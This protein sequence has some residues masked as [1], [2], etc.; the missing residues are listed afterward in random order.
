MPH[1]RAC[2]VLVFSVVIARAV[3]SFVEWRKARL[4]AKF[5]VKQLCIAS[6]LGMDSHVRAREYQDWYQS[7]LCM[8]FSLESFE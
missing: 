2:L 5:A 6:F 1:A 3:Q 8:V 7:C 4:F